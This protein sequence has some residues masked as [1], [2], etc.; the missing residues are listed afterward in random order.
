LQESVSVRA[1]VLVDTLR[2][3]VREH[4]VP[5][6]LAKYLRFW[7]CAPRALAHEDELLDEDSLP[8]R[9]AAQRSDRAPH[10]LT[11]IHPA[12]PRFQ[13]M[14]QDDSHTSSEARAGIGWTVDLPHEW[15]QFRGTPCANGL[16]AGRTTHM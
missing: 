9:G 2:D 3:D 14:V 8:A 12:L 6:A 1:V 13:R 16:T 15:H 7:K 10:R 11:I 5:N 4:V